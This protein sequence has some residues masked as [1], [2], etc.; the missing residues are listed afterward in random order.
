MLPVSSFSVLTRLAR[1]AF[2]FGVMCVG[3]SLTACGSSHDDAAS[4]GAGSG[5]GSASSGSALGGGTT[6][7]QVAVHVS[8]YTAAHWNNPYWKPFHPNRFLE[9]AFISDGTPYV[10]V[11]DAT[12]ESGGLLSGGQPKY[13]ILFS[14]GTESVS[15]TEAAQ[16]AAYVQAGGTVYA[17]ASAWTRYQDGTLRRDGA[18]NA[19][20]ALGSAM[21]LTPAGWQVIDS[22]HVQDMGPMVDHLTAGTTYPWHLA[23]AYDDMNNLAAAH[24]VFGA[25]AAVSAPDQRNLV[26][27]G[28]VGILPSTPSSELL[29]NDSW[30]DPQF[31]IHF[32][33]V[34]GDSGG[35]QDLIYRVGDLV[36]V[37]MS[38]GHGFGPAV[39]WTTWSTAY[40]F[41]IADV[42]GDGKAD[43]V[44]RSGTDIQVGLSTGNGF[45]SST[46]W[47]TW[48]TSYDYQLADVNGDGKADIIGRSADEASVQVGLS[49]GAALA[50]STQWAPYE[51]AT[52]VQFAD[53]DGDHRADYV[54]RIGDHI[55]VRR[56]LAG[57]PGSFAAAADWSYWSPAYTLIVA[58]LD[59]DGKADAT[60][61]SAAADV[62]VGLSTGSGF[63]V[64]SN[65]TPWNGAFT[66]AFADVDGDGR[67]DAVGC[68]CSATAGVYPPGDIET[69]LST[70]RDPALG[71]PTFVAL[72]HKTYGAGDIIYNTELVP[73][74]GYG[75]F[76]NDNSEYKTIRTAVQQAFQRSALPLVTLAP[77]PFPN[78]AAMIYRHDHWLAR[79]IHTAEIG[80]VAAG[81]KFGEYYVLPEQAGAAVCGPNGAQVND[82][83]AQVPWA[84]G[85]GALIG[86]HTLGHVSMDS[87]G[88]SEA[89]SRLQS[90]IQTI[91]AQTGNAMSPIFVAPAYFAIKQSSL[92][93]IRDAGFVATGEQGVGPF[94][95]FAIDPEAATGYIGTLL[96]VP[97][98]EWPGYDNMERLVVNHPTINQAAK[99]AFDL[100]GLVNVYDHAAGD[101]Y[102]YGDPSVN[103]CAISRL[104]LAQG[105]LDYVR[106]L[107][108]AKGVQVWRSSS[109]ELRDWALQRNRHQ[110]SPSVTRTAATTTIAVS[111]AASAPLAATPFSES[112]TALRISL[113]SIALAQA[114]QRVAVSLDGV[115]VGA[116][117]SCSDTSV[118]R[119]SGNDLYV[120]VGS[121][122][123]AS[124]Q[125]GQ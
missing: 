102:G 73:L 66:L 63:V 49:T 48:R 1:V 20:F 62:Q 41:R 92:R 78:Q 97:T 7:P 26:S 105:L 61:R 25:V 17:G 59:G 47:T 118:V 113:D 85:N 93:A 71:A 32:G 90:T 76:A 16:I 8:A 110:L 13:P 94:P 100:G 123:N 80:Y 99:L 109:L 15:D 46:A 75:G 64:S 51:T 28:S 81:R 89:L 24:R 53:V 116:T 30:D 87:F 77:W 52:D 115:G 35:R 95:H 74:A 79:D 34:D 122:R 69:G 3:A 60:G 124:V 45:Q 12:I 44:G 4:S 36:Y 27:L 40:D 107:E 106:S 86:A 10:E 5:Q 117:H 67:S 98:S 70:G 112:G 23:Y 19:V 38:N 42:N 119:C 57:S 11:S 39:A 37:R 121:A 111:I 125:L 104:S 22:V 56:S 65:W 114:R 101:T 9:E 83:Y 103:P 14:L 120:Q 68:Y 29:P 82:Y 91:Q 50:S 108:N 6:H 55:Y 88:Y 2:P 72:S 84:V 18:G 43:I 31:Q 58:D 54:Y 96:E 21:G 33:N